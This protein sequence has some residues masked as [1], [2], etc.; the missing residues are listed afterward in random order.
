MRGNFFAQVDVNDVGGVLLACSGTRDAFGV[1]EGPPSGGRNASSLLAA[2][3]GGEPQLTYYHGGGTS[4]RAPLAQFS[5]PRTT[6]F[7]ASSG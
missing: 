7:Q 3:C 6:S 2:F 5:S 4:E 1:W